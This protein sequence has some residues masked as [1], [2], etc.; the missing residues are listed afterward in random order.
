M[1]MVS[2]CRR[3]LLPFCNFLFYYKVIFAVTCAVAGSFRET[4]WRRHRRRYQTGVEGGNDDDDDV[5]S[6]YSIFISFYHA[7][8]MTK[9][10]IVAAAHTHNCR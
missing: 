2:N 5:V 1:H 3:D 10:L 8:N 4:C 7:I 6:L 9:L